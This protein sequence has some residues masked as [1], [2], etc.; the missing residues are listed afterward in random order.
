MLHGSP[1]RRGSAGVWKS[2]EARAHLHDRSDVRCPR[3]AAVL[4]WRD[5][6]ELKSMRVQYCGAPPRSTA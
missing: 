1:P 5:R 4:T 2:E 6:N 3:P